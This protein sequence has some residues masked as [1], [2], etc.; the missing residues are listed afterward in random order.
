MQP[1]DAAIIAADALVAGAGVVTLYYAWRGLG[2]LPMLARLTTGLVLAVTVLGSFGF[3]LLMF[4]AGG[5]AFVR[6][7]RM[8]WHAEATA[9]AADAT[10]DAA[11]RAPRGVAA[12]SPEAA[13][14]TEV[15][16][17]APPP[18]A[19]ATVTPD[20][21]AASTDGATG[22]ASA[23]APPAPSSPTVAVESAPVT[24][25]AATPPAAAGPDAVAPATA[26]PAD[27]APTPGAVPIS[28]RIA[29]LFGTDRAPDPADGQRFGSARG[30]RLLLG[31]AEVDPNAAADAPPRPW[32]SRVI[33]AAARVA[34]APTPGGGGP[35]LDIVEPARWASLVADAIAASPR[36]DARALVVVHGY[37]TSLETA[38][39]RAA[40]LARDLAF[41]GLVVVYSWPSE[42]RVA[43]YSYDL[44]SARQS[45]PFL[46]EFMA[47]LAGSGIKS[48]S[49][50]VDGV[51]A[52]PALAALARLQVPAGSGFYLDQVMLAAPD[53]DAR[54]LA[55]LAAAV[56][57]S[58][59]GVT[60]YAAAEDRALGVARR[61]HGGRPRA[62]DVAAGEPMVIAGIDTIDASAAGADVAGAGSAQFAHPGAV[63][64]DMAALLRSGA[65]PPDQ[66]GKAQRVATR[67]GGVFWRLEPQQ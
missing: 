28:G 46:S 2:G 18:V 61:F 33:A 48:A 56:R 19:V 51:G 13:P 31:H 58:A 50:L 5:H 10:S 17:A 66:R 64:A 39:T 26:P 40:S 27:A 65:R 7:P 1:N 15:A 16:R 45:E 22:P 38:L 37:N 53:L 62:G 47:V 43:S 23:A 3:V 30:G 9:G 52:G 67:A 29:V 41:E 44:A 59:R 35:A 25:A 11:A 12:S 21:A 42:G 55:D 8:P 60:L 32:T 20:G 14:P 24:V 34:G 57:G 36:G 4:G 49:I 6:E 63:A 54:Q